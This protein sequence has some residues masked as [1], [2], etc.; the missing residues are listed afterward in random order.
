MTTVSKVQ[1]KMNGQVEQFN[2]LR[3]VAADRIL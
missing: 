1:F 2:V 3:K